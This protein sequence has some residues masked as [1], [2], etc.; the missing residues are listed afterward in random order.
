LIP[1]FYDPTQ[2]R[3][4]VDGI[5]LRYLKLQD[6]RRQIGI[7]SQDVFLF[8][9]SIGEN[10]AIVKNGRKKQQEI[11]DAAKI[12]SIHDFIM[13]L[14]EGYKTLV[15]ERGQ[16]LSGGQKQRVA[17]ARALLMD[18][19]ILILDDSLSAVDLD[20]EAKIQQALDQLVRKRT[21]FV[22][23]QR[24]STIQNCDRI[25]VLDGGLIAEL[26]THAELFAKNGI[27][28]RIYNTMYKAQTQVP[29]STALETEA[30]LTIT[31]ETQPNPYQGLPLSDAKTVAAFYEQQFPDAEARQKAELKTVARIEKYKEQEEKKL[32]KETEETVESDQNKSENEKKE[33][34]KSEE[35]H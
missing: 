11:E 12:A 14:P 13:S 18:P 7:V 31:T 24:I 27:Y 4:L 26:G 23:T 29:V 20:T 19:K 10:I 3:I 32:A 28:T 15:G 2:G 22:I 34:K 33:S 6:Y 5:D 9:R 25:L 21:T 16:T 8:S 17:I 30:K 35:E 1:R